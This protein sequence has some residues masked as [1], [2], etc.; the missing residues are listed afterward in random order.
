MGYPVWQT[1][2]GDLGKISAQEFFNLSLQALDPDLNGTIE[3]KLVAGQ[4]PKGLQIASNGFIS[5]NP[6]ATYTLQGVPFSTNVD[7][8]SLFT[9]RAM[10]SYDQTITDRTFKLTVT[11]NFKPV[12]TTV[13]DPLGTYLD[14]TELNLQLEAIDLNDDILEWN[15]VSGS[16]PKGV[17]LSK[18][19]LL[20]GIIEPAVYQ[21]STDVVGWSNS[22][23]NNANWEFET[24]SNNQSYEFTVSVNDTK[25]ASYRKYRINVFAF[26]DLR[27]DNNTI[28]ADTLNITAD[29]YPDR[30]P[31]LIT[32]TLGEFVKVNSGGYYAFKFDAID[33][34]ISEITYVI[35]TGLGL[36]WDETGQNWDMLDWDRGEAS[37]PPGLHLDPKTGWLTGYIPT[38]QETIKDYTF[39]ISVYS[40]NDVSNISKIRYFTLTVLG[41]LDLAVNWITPADLGSI[42]V[43]SISN[44]TV[45]AI[46]ASGRDLTYSLKVGSQ[47]PQGLT[48]LN[49]GHISGKVSFQ[50]MGF[51]KGKTTFDKTL[52]SKFVYKD[53]INF[54]NVY[55]FSVLANDFANQL[56]GEQT[57]TLRVIPSTY[58][59]YE[60]LYIKCLPT[61][62][63]R[64]ALTQIVNNTD[65][66]DPNDVYRPNDP[67]YGVSNEIRILASYG[68]KASEMGHQTAHALIATRTDDI[69]TL[70]TTDIHGLSIGDTITV[71]ITQG[72]D[73]FNTVGKILDIP[74]ID[75]ISYE[76][77]GPDI[78]IMITD[79][80]FSFT[81]TVTKMNTYIQS[82][83]DRH[84]T[85]K[86]Y[87]GDYKVAQGKD[88]DGNLL[89]DVLYVDLIEDTK[90]YQ[91]EK[92]VVKNKIPA[93][94]TNINTIKPNW[95]NPRAAGLPQNQLYSSSSTSVNKTYVKTNDTFFPFEPLNKISPNDL[96]L[97][98]KDIA[99]GLENSYLNS[100]PE[101]MVSVQN[102]GKILGY[103]AGAPLAYLKPG[104]GAKAL[105][106]MKR[107]APS[108]IKDIPFVVD[109]YILDNKYTENFDLK[110]RKFT[111]HKYTTFNLTTAVGVAITPVFKADFAVD[112]PFSSINLQTL[113][114]IIETG[115]LD[116][117]TYNLDGKYLIFATQEAYT[118][119]G[120][121][122]NDGWNFYENV[123]V[124]G[125]IEKLNIPSLK[126]QRGGIWQ[127]K[128]NSDN[129]LE[130]I[131]VREINPGEYVYVNEGVAHGNGYLLYDI[132][133]LV[134]GYT[135]PK[136]TQTYSQVLEKS[137]NPTTFDKN[138]TQF[139][140]NV[141]SYTMPM[142]G[143]KYLKFPKIGVFTN[144]Q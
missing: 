105:F 64:L 42:Y 76:N 19:G 125:Y 142:Q 119:W 69:A 33:W 131:F 75:Q 49:N 44:Q 29:V 43:G 47:L 97:M 103:T 14:G 59:P 50:L 87:F 27:A 3:Y 118:G 83:M 104:T 66:I 102:D 37:L 58:E 6:E 18:S 62:N 15:V 53:N 138:K 10:N 108:D 96:T 134:Q 89:Y 123:I 94:F 139:I 63:K 54:D 115:G 71:K 25:A 32:K 56:S 52:A 22:K 128:I 40:N 20:S 36:G 133:A 77:P 129:I 117:I 68:I 124:P 109:R 92:S 78:D 13:A 72:D 85:K 12:I 101:W 80:G 114:Y 2:A 65:I 31:I 34:D 45:E 46:A 23:W 48:L 28:T 106:N 67:Y 24:R 70:T 41:N 81:G 17:T 116:G 132:T 121:L 113:D 30:P 21:F 60:N 51:D 57:F 127:I 100:L 93:S 8:D 130:L 137:L 122:V 143:A 86:F 7:V 107:Y 39:G 1:K 5:G 90:V 126:N 26:N 144:G 120:S 98:Q 136:Y 141:D 135:V 112:R 55:T 16:L 74:A 111:A 35:N 73:T 11:G 9:I 84:Y 91:I 88:V 110:A 99:L 4:L 95:R 82:M 79:P 38:Q 140:N 61:V